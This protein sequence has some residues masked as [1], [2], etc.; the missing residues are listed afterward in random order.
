VKTKM[1]WLTKVGNLPPC[2]AGHTSVPAPTDVAGSILR[3]DCLT[4]PGVYS[5]PTSMLWAGF[6]PIS[7][8]ST[9]SRIH[10]CWGFCGTGFQP[11]QQGPGFQPV[12]LR[13]HGFVP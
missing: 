3:I 11:T 2:S 4:D 12:W 8:L 9:P 1:C 10:L 7:R 6:V 13:Y 5:N